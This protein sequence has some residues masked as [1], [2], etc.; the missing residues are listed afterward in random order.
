MIQYAYNKSSNCIVH[1]SEVSKAEKDNYN[2]KC[3][4]CEEDIIIKDGIINIKHFSHKGGSHTNNC[5]TE[6]IEHKAAKLLLA[7]Y[8]NAGGKVKIKSCSCNSAVEI[9]NCTAEVEYKVFNGKADI[10]VLDE[11]KNIKCLFEIKQTHETKSRIE[12]WFEFKAIDVL[13]QLEKYSRLEEDLKD[14]EE[15]TLNDIRPC[16]CYQIIQTRLQSNYSKESYIKSK[17]KPKTLLE[18][19]TELDFYGVFNDFDR[20]NGRLAL[21]CRG[22]KKYFIKE[23][24]ISMSDRDD[25][26]WNSI[27]AKFKK[28]DKCLK[29]AKFCVLGFRKVYCDTCYKEI[30][31]DKHCTV[32]E[33]YVDQYI[34]ETIKRCFNWLFGVTER[35]SSYGMC[36]ICNKKSNLAW[37]HGN[38][39]ICTECVILKHREE[40]PSGKY[41]NLGEDNWENIATSY[42][43]ES[44]REEKE[45]KKPEQEEIVK[46]IIRRHSKLR[47]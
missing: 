27:H 8:I 31:E 2:L 16:F 32:T 22:E 29:C 21:L 7:N 43:I 47:D 25:F 46:R 11:N 33:I 5:S 13:N 28:R 23:G 1:I 35:K 6:S 36:R 44:L 26:E 40:Y 45:E 17:T 30:K 15:I 19:A 39:A 24:W 18:I 12:K 20:I 3:L 10:A 42:G 34:L 38:R 37:F 4:K 9:K 41:L 14:G